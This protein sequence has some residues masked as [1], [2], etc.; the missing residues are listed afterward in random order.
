MAVLDHPPPSRAAGALARPDLG[1]VFM[2][3]WPFALEGG[4]RP[5][6]AAPVPAARW[7]EGKPIYRAEFVVSAARRIGRSTTCSGGGSRTTRNTAIPAGTC[8]SRTWPRWAPH[9]SPHAWARSSR[10]SARSALSP[11]A[12]PTWPALTRKSRPPAP[13]RPRAR[14]RCPRGGGHNRQPN[15]AA[16]GRRARTRRR[17]AVADRAPRPASPCPACWR[18]SHCAASSPFRH[19]TIRARCNPGPIKR[20]DHGRRGTSFG[21]RRARGGAG[22]RAGHACARGGPAD[23][24]G[25]SALLGMVQDGAPIYGVS[26]GLGAAV[27]TRARRTGRSSSAASRSPARSVWAAGRQGTRCGP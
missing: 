11:R 18:R 16:G 23:R 6:I 4:I 14:R 17:A 24:G 22:W 8:R 10:T 9:L 27:D 5:I 13:A 1:A 2:C 25:A 21:C 20:R 7:S 19:R 15:P 26:T 12:R 3:G